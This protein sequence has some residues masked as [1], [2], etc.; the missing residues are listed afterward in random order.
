MEII[1]K[2]YKWAKPLK[3]R[4]VKKNVDIIAL[5]HS[6]SGLN[7]T[8]DMIHSGHLKLGWAGIGY[9]FVITPDGKV[10][11]GRPITAVG[12]NVAGHNS[13]VIGIC[14]IGNFDIN[15]NVPTQAQIKSG[16]ELIIDLFKIKKFMIKG[17]RDLMATACPGRF[18]P[19]DK[20]KNL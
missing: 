15:K 1:N 2:K 17:H 13:H 10:Y 9:H 19:M 18:F 16:Q 20:L 7:L 5:H 8:P 11:M 3:Y 4:D 6:A 12:A 14:F